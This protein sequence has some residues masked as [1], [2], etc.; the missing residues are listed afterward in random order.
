MA[1]KVKL[2]KR[3]LASGKITLYLDYYPPVRN[4][5]TM[6]M[7]RHEYLGIYL[8]KDPRTQSERQMNKE[9][10]A[11][12]QAIR[13]QREISVINEEYG[14]LDKT[15][16]AM[17]VLDY[18][19]SLLPDRDPKWSVV[20]EHFRIF[21]HGKCTFAELTPDL[22]TRFRDYLLTAKSLK[23]ESV[24]LSQNSAA[25]YWSSFRAFLALAYKNK[26][27]GENINDYLDSIT[28][29][30]THREYLTIEELRRLYDT[31][32]DYPVLKA[33]S[34]FSC[35]TGLRISDILRLQWSNIQDFPG[36]GKCIRIRTE[37][38]DTDA[39][40]P[41]SDQALNLCGQQDQGPIFKGLTRVMVNTRLKPWLQA[42]GIDK[43]ITFH[44]FRHTYATLM[45]AG[46]ADIYTVSKM[47]THKSVSTTQIYADLVSE[48]KKQ[49]SEIIKI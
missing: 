45:I 31:P 27:I 12:A 20:Y 23:T 37:K 39:T 29:L 17:S 25:G 38:T 41:I 6:Q 21:T 5:R 32:C 15:T 8:A 35:L 43:H 49:A 13:S 46:G 40:I 48:K 18:F 4:P 42:A 30:E 10:L 22:C 2:R 3:P 24:S 19:R 16:K 33:A 1:T 14:F 44:C 47:L 34:L 26:L 9:K 11:Q 28:T 36:G 7:V